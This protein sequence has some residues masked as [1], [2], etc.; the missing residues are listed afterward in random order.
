MQHNQTVFFCG[1][2][3]G[4]LQALRR[5]ASVIETFD[6]HGMP[7]AEI[8]SVLENKAMKQHCAAAR[9]VASETFAA[10]RKM[11]SGVQYHAGRRFSGRQRPLRFATVPAQYN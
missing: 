2:Y 5:P 8:A 1:S 9:N 3:G 11:L 6:A 10:I 4:L 7:A